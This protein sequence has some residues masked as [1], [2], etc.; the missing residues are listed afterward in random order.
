MV[1]AIDSEKLKHISRGSFEFW[2][3]DGGIQC[4]DECVNCVVEENRS[5]KSKRGQVLSAT[6]ADSVED[7]ADT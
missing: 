4:Q 1:Q 5:K 2:S 3:D 6:S 7:K